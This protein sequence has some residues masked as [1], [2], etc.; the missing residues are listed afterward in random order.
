MAEHS[1]DS[2]RT[3]YEGKLILIKTVERQIIQLLSMDHPRCMDSWH[4]DVWSLRCMD[5]LKVPDEGV[6]QAAEVPRNGYVYTLSKISTT[7]VYFLQL[8][9]WFYKT[10]MCS[11]KI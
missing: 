8:F 11:C 3:G 9:H 10:P 6:F 5:V 2:V 1:Y 7:E 4:S